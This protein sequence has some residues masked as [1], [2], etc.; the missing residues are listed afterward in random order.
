[1]TFQWATDSKLNDFFHDV[2]IFTNFRTFHE[3][4]WFFHDLETDLN[5]NDFSRAV[6]T[7]NKHTQSY[8][9]S[10]VIIMET[11][12]RL[13]RLHCTNFYKFLMKP[14][15]SLLRKLNRTDMLSSNSNYSGFIATGFF[16]IPWHFPD[17]IHISLTKCNKKSVNDRFYRAY[18]K[19]SDP[20]QKWWCQQNNV[21]S[22]MR[23]FEKILIW[24]NF[25]V[26]I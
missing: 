26:S 5:F 13:V 23:L 17:S 12:L 11:M 25:Y 10:T 1:M 20:W 21:K 24:E 9:V 7:L 22:I 14:V 8:G 2:L 16:K 15:F 3:I 4:Q 6:G 18:L 19:I